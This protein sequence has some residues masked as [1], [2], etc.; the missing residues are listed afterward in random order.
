MPKKTQWE[1]THGSP[2]HPMQGIASGKYSEVDKLPRHSR[3]GINRAPR[4]SAPKWRSMGGEFEIAPIVEARQGFVLEWLWA[5]SK[6]PIPRP[7]RVVQ[8]TS[9]FVGPASLRTLSTPRQGGQSLRTLSTTFHMIGGGN[10]CR[11][12]SCHSRGKWRS[13]SLVTPRATSSRFRMRM[14]ATA[15]PD[16]VLLESFGSET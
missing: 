14:C 10:G 11:G 6:W 15:W 4:Q 1:N 2:R 3:E 13:R 16:G 8:S 5:A 9:E 12:P 7:G